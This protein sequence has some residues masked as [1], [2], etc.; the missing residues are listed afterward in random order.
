MNGMV[1]SIV[2]DFGDFNVEGKLRELKA[3]KPPC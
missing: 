1:E 3:L 2:L